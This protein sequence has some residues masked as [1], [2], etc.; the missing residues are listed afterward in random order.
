MTALLSACHCF[1]TH[2]GLLADQLGAVRRAVVG[3]LINA[4]QIAS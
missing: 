3:G 2:V 4:Y 1:A